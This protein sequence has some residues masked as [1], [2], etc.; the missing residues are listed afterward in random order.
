MPHYNFECELGGQQASMNPMDVLREQLVQSSVRILR[1]TERLI[2]IQQQRSGPLFTEDEVE[3]VI[4][5]SCKGSFAQMAELK[6]FKTLETLETELNDQETINHTMIGETAVLRPMI[7]ARE[8]MT[9]F[10]G[11]QGDELVLYDP[12]GLR[13]DGL[14]QRGVPGALVVRSEEKITYDRFMTNLLQQWDY[15][16]YLD[17][18][19]PA[20]KAEELDEFYI[21][22]TAQKFFENFL[23]VL[24]ASLFS[25]SP[26]M[27]IAKAVFTF[28][29]ALG[30]EA[31]SR[32]NTAEDAS[33]ADKFKTAV[34]QVLSTQFQSE[35]FLRKFMSTW[36]S[37][38]V[39]DKFM[40]KNLEDVLP[41]LAQSFFNMSW[42]RLFAQAIAAGGGKLLDRLA[43]GAKGSKLL[44]GMVGSAGGSVFQYVMGDTSLE[45]IYLYIG[46]FF[47]TFD[48]IIEGIKSY[49]STMDLNP[50][51]RLILLQFV[52]LFITLSRALKSHIFGISTN[53]DGKEDTTTTFDK[54]ERMINALRFV[55][56]LASTVLT[57]KDN[58]NAMLESGLEYI[59]Q[60]SSA[61]TSNLI[62]DKY[63]K[64]LKKY[65]NN[66]SFV[67]K[68]LVE[69]GSYDASERFIGWKWKTLMKITLTEPDAN[70]T[71]PGTSG[72]EAFCA[73]FKKYYAAL[74]AEMLLL[75]SEAVS[76][77]LQIA[78]FVL[79]KNKYLRG[80]N[81]WK[82]HAAF[83][84]SA[85]VFEKIFV[86]PQHGGR[87]DVNAPQLPSPTPWLDKVRSTG[88]WD[89]GKS[90]LSYAALATGFITS[91][92]Y[93]LP[94]CAS[95]TGNCLG[96]KLQYS[97]I[98]CA[99]GPRTPDTRFYICKECV[100]NIMAEQ[101]KQE[102]PS[103]LN[104]QQLGMAVITAICK[105]APDKRF[106]DLQD[107]MKDP[108][109]F[110]TMTRKEF[111]GRLI[112]TCT[113]KKFEKQ[114]RLLKLFEQ[115]ICPVVIK[116][117][118]QGPSFFSPS[119]F[120]S[121]CFD[122]ITITFFLFIEGIINDNFFDTDL[123]DPGKVKEIKARYQEG[124]FCVVLFWGSLFRSINPDLNLEPYYDNDITGRAFEEADKV[125]Y[126]TL[127]N[128]L[129]T[130]KKAKVD[131][132]DF[133]NVSNNS[134]GKI[135]N[136]FNTWLQSMHVQTLV[137][138]IL[139]NGWLDKNA[140]M[141]CV[142]SA[143]VRA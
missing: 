87:V 86:R 84:F 83:A 69:A 78:F 118:E 59:G 40:F 10:A 79:Q 72:F 15:N 66:R 99:L 14:R 117:D 35:V 143:E 88:W 116:Y 62:T 75:G 91:Y 61:D 90:G 23:V 124:V 135:R 28:W 2:E 76:K 11:V 7:A 109:S 47:S 38:T 70:N 39:I 105:L 27:A 3:E 136:G 31:I 58:E 19:T 103:V 123:I 131:V 53:S 101:R 1:R 98:A 97:S 138:R 36:L 115:D 65:A 12:D 130:L 41:E 89:Q 25:R 24:T 63:K 107:D 50:E 77:A 94:Q 44:G 81:S 60:V 67:E 29:V 95:Q 125:L 134:S 142:K 6:A 22:A 9:I 13:R 106:Y 119:A 55:I 33:L 71:K 102:T 20:M 80:K 128:L 114:A 16:V 46:G 73:V 121:L 64:A 4:Q 57:I 26:P 51:L 110:S 54:I 96:F 113:V 104:N 139:R 74:G 21:N 37:V 141:E 126:R 92:I 34:K 108:S 42:K 93:G 137:Y 122:P 85:F 30:R 5:M 127:Q 120:I 32:I 17:R 112:D 43:T 82:L 48:G 18:F 133:G 129:D 45:G 132:D 140:V 8:A 68:A 56:E 49:I 111:M 100:S 52:S